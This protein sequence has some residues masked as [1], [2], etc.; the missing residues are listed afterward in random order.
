MQF[1]SAWHLGSGRLAT[2]ISEV[3]VAR[4]AREGDSNYPDLS[5][6]FA[7]IPAVRI[8]S[9]D[10]LSY[11]TTAIVTLCGLLAMVGRAHSDQPDRAETP[12]VGEEASAADKDALAFGRSVPILGNII[13][14]AEKKAARAEDAADRARA[15]AAQA[16]EA[17]DRA[18]KAATRARTEAKKAKAEAKEAKAEAKEA[19]AEAKKAKA[20][21]REAKASE[22]AARE[23]E[24]GKGKAVVD[25]VYQLALNAAVELVD[26]QPKR[27]IAKKEESS[28]TAGRLNGRFKYANWKNGLFL[29]DAELSVPPGRAINLARA[30]VV[31]AKTGKE[32][33]TGIVPPDAPDGPDLFNQPHQKII[34]T[35]RPGQ[36]K[37]LV[38]V[39]KMPPGQPAKGLE[40]KLFERGSD[41]PPL[42]V[43]VPEFTGVATAILVAMGPKTA[44][45]HRWARQLVAGPRISWGACWLT[46]GQDGEDDLE[47]TS[48]MAAGAYVSRGFHEYVALE[49]EAVGGATG[50]ARFDSA[51][52]PRTRS[53]KF[54]RFTGR[55]AARFADGKTVPFVALGAGIQGTSYDDPDSDLDIAA[56]FTVGGGLLYRLGEHWSARADVSLSEVREDFYRALDVGV[57]L[58][59]GWNLWHDP[60]KGNFR[61]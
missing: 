30:K 50:E 42:A 33:T 38:F 2:G 27:L 8:A 12:P 56:F 14:R 13:I 1:R 29:F 5:R 45:R 39:V 20:E 34:A 9:E 60:L 55:A 48:C 54:G 57:S 51:Q 25:A 6:Q 44:Q 16:R 35:I 37:R 61:Q 17:A 41:R 59:Y 47:N 28:F 4:L 24:R 22:R 32:L 52:G 58:S 23:R 7:L 36:K 40:L 10:A 3:D 46:S 26:D 19:G 11:P 18:K 53:A 15:D 49:V 21:A 43:K 31:V